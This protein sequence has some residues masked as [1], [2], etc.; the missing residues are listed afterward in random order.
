M[1][2]RVHTDIISEYHFLKRKV[3]K[4]IV[5]AEQTG[6]LHQP[7][8]IKRIAQM[9]RRLVVIEKD[10]KS[11]GMPHP[12]AF[13]DEGG[14]TLKQINDEL[15]YKPQMRAAFNPDGTLYS[16]HSIYQHE[17]LQNLTKMMIKSNPDGQLFET[18]AMEGSILPRRTEAD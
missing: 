8:M 18:P 2:R 9:M 15:F 12:D 16:K 6:P 1:T 7:R 3:R 17:G 4:M 5:K 14:P 10:C 13:L 11:M